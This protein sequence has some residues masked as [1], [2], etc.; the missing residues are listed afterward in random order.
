MKFP[1]YSGFLRLAL[2]RVRLS[3]GLDRR[4][5]HIVVNPLTNN[6]DG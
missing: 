1:F 3:A 6:K 4:L 2:F 5:G